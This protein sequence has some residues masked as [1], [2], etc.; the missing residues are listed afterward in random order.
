MSMACWGCT[1]IGKSIPC[2]PQRHTRES[3]RHDRDDTEPF[4]RTLLGEPLEGK[5]HEWFLW[6]G[7]GNGPSRKVRHRASSLPDSAPSLGSIAAEDS[8]R[9][10]RTS[11]ARRSRSCASPQSASCSENSVISRE[12]PGRTLRPQRIRD[13]VQVNRYEQVSLTAKLSEIPTSPD[14]GSGSSKM[15]PPADGRPK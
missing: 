13:M 4:R 14:A 15:R 12:V 5:L 3:G 6:G 10:G 7:T 1:G 11:T 9:I 2:P 8:P